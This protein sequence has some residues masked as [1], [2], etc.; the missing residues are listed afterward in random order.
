MSG[1]RLL[2]AFA[3][4]IAAYEI[5]YFYP[6]MPS[7][8]AVHFNAAGAADGWGPKN[9]FFITIGGVIALLATLFAGISLLIRVLPDSM[10]NLPNKA[11]WLAPE[12][13][14][15]THKRLAGQLLFIGAITLLLLDG[16]LYLSC[17][18]NIPPASSMP[19]DILW[20]M[21]GLFFSINIIWTILMI[22]SYR[23]PA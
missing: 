12:R 10:V 17:M 16:V 21:L 6:I 18:A 9:Y 7:P 5:I 20:G 8:M 2:F 3:I 1:T 23:R 13:R 14:V 22:R 15:L 19:A 4:L 11:Y